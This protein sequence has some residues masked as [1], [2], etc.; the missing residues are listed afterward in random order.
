MTDYEFFISKTPDELKEA[1]TNKSA[2]LLNIPRSRKLLQKMFNLTEDSRLKSYKHIAHQY[3][4]VLKFDLFGE[5]DLLT[6]IRYVYNSYNIY[7]D[8]NLYYDCASYDNDSVS[9]CIYKF[10][11][12]NNRNQSYW[13][14]IDN[15]RK[16]KLSEII[17]RV[18]KKRKDLQICLD[19]AKVWFIST[20]IPKIIKDEDIFGKSEVLTFNLAVD[21]LKNVSTKYT[22]LDIVKLVLSSKYLKISDDKLLS[23]L[24]YYCSGYYYNGYYSE[25]GSCLPDNFKYPSEYEVDY[26][27]SRY[28]LAKKEFSDIEKA[29]RE[30]YI[31]VDNF[32]KTISEKYGVSENLINEKCFDM[33]NDILKRLK[34]ID[35]RF[36]DF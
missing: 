26:L 14:K 31:V 10:K 11:D 6:E 13:Y 32:R 25:S 7:V 20:D 2:G 30:F 4:I 29:N 12:F 33:K 35:E 15:I 21:I 3:T 28:N 17:S 34:C 36:N 1:F 9:Y 23:L 16:L 27:L 24:N 8:F 22:L 19:M 5:K 18:S